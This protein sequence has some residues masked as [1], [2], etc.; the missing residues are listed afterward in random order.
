MNPAVDISFDCIPLRSV[1][2]LDVPV[3]A[4]PEQKELGTRIRAAVKRHGV[5]NT[6]YLCNA[7]C[8]FRLTNHPEVG[9]LSF[10]FEGTVMTDQEDRKT[11]GCDLAVELKQE[12]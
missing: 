4:T 8:V 3:D 10:D 5:F 9:M 6:F 12:V 1:E 7:K 11:V 2:R